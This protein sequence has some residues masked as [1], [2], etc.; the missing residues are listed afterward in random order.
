MRQALSDAA[1]SLPP[2]G[3]LRL[4]GMIDKVDPNP[5]RAA[6]E[7]TAILFDQ[8]SSEDMPE[9]QQA[10]APIEMDRS[11]ASPR[12]MVPYVVAIV[13]AITVA[14]AAAALAHVGAEPVKVPG[15]IGLTQIDA[16]TTASRAGLD[17]VGVERE[18]APDPA[19]MVIDQKPEPG[20][21]TRGAKVRLTVSNGPAKVAIPTVVQQ[22]WPDA[23]RTLDTAG[24]V[25]KTPVSEQYDETVPAG[26]VLSVT[27]APGARVAPNTEL[28]ITLSKGH[29]PVKVPDVIGKDIRRRDR[30]ARGG[31]PPRAAG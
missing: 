7:K 10:P 22:A 2:P 6:P 28:Q 27:P 26:V 25:Y 4:A 21:W 15:L 30:G 20:V 11:S 13:L 24:F 12:R 19:G 31:A 16:R 8:D 17:V 9:A 3:P 1:E 29:A 23:Q 5:T 18:Q 14:L